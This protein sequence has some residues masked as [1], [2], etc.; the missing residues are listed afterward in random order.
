MALQIFTQRFTPAAEIPTGAAAVTWRDAQETGQAGHEHTFH[1]SLAAAKAQYRRD[2][3]NHDF[4]ANGWMLVTDAER[5]H[6]IM[7]W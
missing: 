7:C 4:R 2:S 5:E 3:A 6:G 1:R